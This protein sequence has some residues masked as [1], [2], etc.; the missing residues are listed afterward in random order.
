MTRMDSGEEVRWRIERWNARVESAQSMTISI[1]RIYASQ[2][3]QRIVGTHT[4]EYILENYRLLCESQKMAIA[5][6][7]R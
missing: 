5:V 3:Y 6:G 1:L 4:E 2:V 7:A